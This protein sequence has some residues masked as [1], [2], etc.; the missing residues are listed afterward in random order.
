MEGLG[1][2]DSFWTVRLL[3]AVSAK[4]LVELICGVIVFAIACSILDASS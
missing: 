3:F 4:G 2:A 1:D